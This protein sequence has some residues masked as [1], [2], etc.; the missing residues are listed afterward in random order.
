MEIFF[1]YLPVNL[2]VFKLNFSES[3]A[4][5]SIANFSESLT[6]NGNKQGTLQFYR[7]F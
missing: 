5:E 4:T 1:F 3:M 7:N 2:H 6:I